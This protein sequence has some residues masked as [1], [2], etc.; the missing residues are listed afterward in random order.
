MLP[1]N[2]F[3]S[4]IQKKNPSF[5]RSIALILH[6]CGCHGYFHGAQKSTKSK[7]LNMRAALVHFV[8]DILQTLAVLVAAIIVKIWV[9][10]SW[11]SLIYLFTVC[12]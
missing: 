1:L 3:P 2:S 12:I 11:F 6:G 8:A 4:Y 10:S 5:P 9:S 7:S